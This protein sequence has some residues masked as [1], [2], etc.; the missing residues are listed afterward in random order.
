MIER[1]PGSPPP[2]A[3]LALPVFLVALALVVLL[4]FQ[5]VLLTRERSALAQ[6]RTGQEPTIAESVRVRQQLE[7]LANG[8]AKLAQEGNASAK[9]IV[10][11]LR[12]QGITINPAR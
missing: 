1:Y 7:S 6:L 5:T 8:V 2:R 9:S 3:R 12:R 4:S 11:D 10:E